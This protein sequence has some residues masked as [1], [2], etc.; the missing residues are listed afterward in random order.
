MILVSMLVFLVGHHASWA[1]AA[2]KQLISRI[3][4]KA[5]PAW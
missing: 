5:L 3:Y 2:E 4:V 1:D